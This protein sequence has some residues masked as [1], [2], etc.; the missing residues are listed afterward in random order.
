[1]R[2]L[3]GDGDR[4]AVAVSGGSDSVALL[5][6]LSELAAKSRWSLSGIVHVNHQLRPEAD[7]DAAFVSDLAHRVSLPIVSTRVDIAQRVRQQRRSMETIAREARYECFEDAAI[8]LGATIVATGHTLDDQAETVMLRLLRGSG[9]RGVAAVRPR[10]GIYVRPLLDCRRTDLRA[11]LASRGQTFCEDVSN[12]SLTIPRNRLRHQ[13]MPIIDDLTA[14]GVRALAR[15][16]R[17]ADADERELTRQARAA[18]VIQ[19]ADDGVQLS[20]AGLAALPAAIARRVVRDAIEQ[21]GGVPTLGHVEAVLALSRAARRTGETHLHG[22]VAARTDEVLLLSR[23]LVGGKPAGTPISREL[24]VPGA[25]ELP[26]TGATIRASFLTGRDSHPRAERGSPRVA[27][28]AD[29]VRTPFVVRT[30]RPGDRIRPLGAPGSRSLQNLFVDRKV[31]RAER[32]VVP[33]VVDAAGRIVWVAGVAI[34]HDCQVTAP[35][36]GMVILELEK[37]RQ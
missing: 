1:M 2:S 28:Q 17:L 36:A 22:L 13:L 31:P 4:V 33:L 37:C 16:A 3:A 34:A 35:E 24:P 6:V 19:S 8:R 11:Y 32:D 21:A 7:A 15:F 26:E 12:L 5:L 29:A 25:I 30:R 10:R 20:V 23:T 27:L 18:S 9:S 14:G